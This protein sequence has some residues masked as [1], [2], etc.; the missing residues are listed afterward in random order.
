MELPLTAGPLMGIGP[1]ENSGV[2]DIMIPADFEIRRVAISGLLASTVLPLSSPGQV[3]YLW[4]TFPDG[5]AV[6]DLDDGGWIYVSNSETTLTGGVGALKFDRNGQLTDSYPILKNTRRNCAGGPSPWQTWL[7][8]EEVSDGRVYECDPL[9][10]PGTARE[11]PALGIFNH[12]AVAVDLKTKTLYLTEDAGDGRLYRFRSSGMAVSINGKPGLDMQNGTLEALEIEGFEAGGYQEDLT[13]A[14][15]VHRVRWVPIHSPDRPQSEVRSEIQKT[16]G[17]GAPGTVFKGGEGI[18]IQELTKDKQP[19]VTG[20]SHPLRA[21][22]YFACKGDNRV[23][24]LD[25]D[26]ELIEVV[27]DNEQLMAPDVPFDDVD[28]ITISPMGDVIVSEDGDAMRLMVMNPNGPSKILLQVPGGGS[29]LTGPAFT[30]NGQ[31]LYFS[32]QRGSA[33]GPGLLGLGITYE[34]K[35]PSRFLKRL[36]KA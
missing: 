3:N 1:L 25:I 17:V 27:F 34:V 31:F 18:W 19:R 36:V 9:G 32:S 21:V 26:N 15:K 5:G 13:E 11:L 16:T 30:R 33:I 8:C 2:D 28:N 24:A 22:V 23:Y 6:F 12:E 20:A 4:H 10:T 29:E 35:V 14:R 7:S